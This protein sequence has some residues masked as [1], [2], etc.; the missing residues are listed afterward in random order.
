MEYWWDDTDK[1]KTE[2]LEKK[3][4]VPPPVPLCPPQI[5]AGLAWNGTLTSEVKALLTALLIPP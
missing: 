1:D 3:N 5:P 4:P 2:G